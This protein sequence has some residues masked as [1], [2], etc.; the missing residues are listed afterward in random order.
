MLVVNAAHGQ[1][2]KKERHSASRCE[3]FKKHAEH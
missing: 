3:Q 2:A 1:Q